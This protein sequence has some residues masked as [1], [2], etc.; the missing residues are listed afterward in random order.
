MAED[1]FEFLNN[2]F[3]KGTKV[4][5][6]TNF[7]DQYMAV[8]FLSLYPGAFLVAEEAN[9]LMGKMPGSATNLFLFHSIGKQR[10]PR[11]TYPKKDVEEKR[12]PKEMI[13]KM[14]S[15]LCCSEQ[16]AIQTLQILEKI[17][18]LL[19]EDLGVDMKSKL[20]GKTK[21]VKHKRLPK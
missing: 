9:R 6:N 16:E 20:K 10:P 7:K 14:A 5:S 4:D 18:P 8:K 2:L 19:L 21:D 1:L 13:H 17:D 12:F 15:R 11:I 3:S